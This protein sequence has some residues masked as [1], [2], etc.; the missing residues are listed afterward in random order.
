MAPPALA[1]IMTNWRKC[2]KR[3]CNTATV[4]ATEAAVVIKVPAQTFDDIGQ[5]APEAIAQMSEGI[6]QRVARDQ[7]ATSLSR[8]FGP[9]SQAALSYVESQ[10]QWVRLRAGE[11]LFTIGETSQD[12]YFV[13]SGRLRAIAADGAILSEIARGESIGEVAL[14]TG[15]PRSATIL[16]VRDSDLVCLSKEVFDR[17]IE[18]YPKV[19]QAIAQVVV[20]R[21]RTKEKSD[22]AHGKPGTCLAVLGIGGDPL[23]SGFTQRLVKA[24]ESIGPALH[25]SSQRVDQA[26]NRPRIA[27]SEK[28][29]AGGI[30]LNA[31]L[32]NQ[33]SAYRFIVYETEAKDCEWTRRC[34]RQAN[35]ILLVAHTSS[36]PAVRGLEHTLIHEGASAPNARQTLLLLHPGGERSPSGTDAWLAGRALHRHFHLRLDAESDFNRVAR[37]LA[38]TATGLVFG[39][40]GAR[41]LA[42]IG[43]IRAFEEAGLPVDMIGG[44]SMGAVIS[45]AFGMGL[46]WKEILEI[47]RTGWLKYKPHK[48]YTIPMVSLIRTRVLDRWAKDVYGNTNIEDLWLSFFCVACN[49][50]ASE[51]VLLDR[52]SLWK[53]VRASS[54]LPGIFVPVMRDG[55]VY[56]DG[57]VV[58]NLPGDLMRKR[59]CQTVM[60]IDVGSERGFSFGVAEF[61]SPW[62]LLWSYFLPFVKKV[63]VPNI[64]ALLLRTTEVSSNQKAVEVKRDADVCLRPP[65]DKFGILDFESI[66][67]IVD[68]GYRYTMERLESMKDDP[69]FS[70][71]FGA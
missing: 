71:L 59:A 31:W 57:A 40:G 26:L 21:L 29:S 12:M 18:K 39:G 49:L 7:L 15:E 52:G 3:S 69:R 4:S 54:A 48:E 44:T 58:N 14:L 19:M 33:E 23:P 28:E 64:A 62:K 6:R 34:L 5:R 20:R 67:Q 16:A 70:K 50:T 41:G 65:I 61:P 36:E 56:V 63:D 60:V 35:E 10:I 2:T 9:M 42:H 55:N 24:F 45:A 46:G 27:N 1:A 30:L 66:D 22:T 11:K 37:C 47:S 17:I 13:V 32:Y 38:G 8:L 51:M 68:T 25:L 43:V 53:A